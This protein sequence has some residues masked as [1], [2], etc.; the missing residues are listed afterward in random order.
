MFGNDSYEVSQTF[1]RWR[2]RRSTLRPPRYKY[3]TKVHAS[4]SLSQEDKAVSTY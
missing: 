2:L 3:N 4:A 1:D